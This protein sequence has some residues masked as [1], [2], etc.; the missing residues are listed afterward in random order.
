MAKYAV[1]VYYNIHLTK[2][3]FMLSG[4]DSNLRWRLLSPD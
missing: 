2:Y 4:Q 1:N 3:K